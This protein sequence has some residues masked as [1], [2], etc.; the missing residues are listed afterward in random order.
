[1]SVSTALPVTQ[2]QPKDYASDAEVRWC[3]GCGDYSILAQIKKV[4]SALGKDP[5]KVVIVSGIG[6]SSRLPYYMGTYGIHGIH[7]RAPAIATG[8]KLAR[9]DL[10]VWVVTGDGDGLSIGGNHLL[11]AIRRNL[12][13]KILLFNNRIYGLT[14]GQVSPTSGINKK[15]VSTPFGSVGGQL[16][17]CSF[18]IGSEATFVARTVDMIPAHLEDT[19]RRAAA[20]EGIAFVEIYQNCNIFNDG[21][22]RHAT[23]REIR[24]DNLVA[25]EHGKALIFG[26][27]KDKGIRLGRGYRPEV[28]SLGEGGASM[29]DL[30]IHDERAPSPALAFLLSRLQYPEYPE[31]IGV[32]RAVRA[33]VYDRLIDEQVRALTAKMGPPD[34]QALLKGPE[35]WEV[36]RS[37]G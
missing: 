7:G 35:T 28:V 24:D 8:I 26:R 17:P 36:A 14:K 10:E 5:D 22:F 20:H 4:F 6:C 19:L 9:Q 1:M 25:L 23:D 15:T 31:P 30:L 3:P 34:L 2:R 32:F 33:P 18:A 13:L 29:Y 37:E 27:D 11:H 12:N 21:A 16:N